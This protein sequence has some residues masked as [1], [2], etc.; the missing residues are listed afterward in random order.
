MKEASDGCDR[1]SK[2][3][4]GI[5]KH[6]WWK[7]LTGPDWVTAIATAMIFLATAVYVYYARKQWSVMS[8]QLS[9]M[10]GQ[11]DVMRKEQRA[12]LS[13]RQVTGTRIALNTA[14]STAIVLGN[15]GKSPAL[16]LVCHVYVEII[17]NGTS[18]HFDAE[19]VHNIMISGVM[20]PGSSEEMAA[21]RRRYKPSSQGETEDFPL[22]AREKVA[23]QDGKS[24]IAVHGTVSY[25]DVFRVG[26][27]TRFCMHA[28]LKE[29]MYQDRA[30]TAYNAVDNN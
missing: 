20:M 19:I 7:P 11:L 22:T 1:R 13:V 18:P 29:G 2:Q 4:Q 30:C 21:I 25:S 26:H 12:W 15:T 14:P 6:P 10:N 24:W 23:L 28:A 17:P 27:W 8:D 3:E 16:A 9:T 5:S